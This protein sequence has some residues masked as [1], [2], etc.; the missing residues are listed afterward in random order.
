MPHPKNKSTLLNFCQS[1]LQVFMFHLCKRCKWPEPPVDG[2]K[3]I[4]QDEHPKV[5]LKFPMPVNKAPSSSEEPNATCL[6]YGAIYKTQQQFYLAKLILF[7]LLHLVTAF[8]DTKCPAFS[9]LKSICIVSN[10]VTSEVHYGRE[11][12]YCAYHRQQSELNNL[13]FKLLMNNLNFPRAF[14]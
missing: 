8:Q 10:L 11:R 5:M 7:S 9:Q 2:N 13:I 4:W 3:Y 12:H 14:P 1:L 6:H